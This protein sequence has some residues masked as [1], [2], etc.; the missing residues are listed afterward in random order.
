MASKKPV[1]FQIAEVGPLNGMLD[2]R[3]LPHELPPNA[4]RWSE[5]MAATA[6]GKVCRRPG[7]EKLFG[8]TTTY[9]NQDLHDQ[10]FDNL[11]QPITLLFEA[12]ST[13][14]THRLIAGT[15]NRLYALN[16]STGNWRVLSDQYGGPALSS[17]SDRN[18]YAA[19]VEDTVVFTNGSDPVVSWPFDGAPGTDDQSVSTIPD[20]ETLHITRAD[21]V[22][23][24]KGVLFLANITADGVRVPYRIVWS[25]F[26]KPL[27]FLP[28]PTVSVAGSHDL[29]YGEDV[30]AM[31]PLADSLLI[32]TTHGIWEAQVTGDT[33]VFSF[34]QR[35]AEPLTGA[36]C[37]AYKRTIVSTGSE[38]VYFGRDGL[39]AYDFYSPKPVRVEW[40]HRASSVIFDE[41]EDSLC[42][43]H[44][45]GWNPNK[46]EVWF[47]WA[48]KGDTNRCPYRTLVVNTEYQFCDVIKRGF[49][50]F[51]SY[52]PT[53]SSSVRDFLLQQCIC[54]EEELESNDVNFVNEGGFCRTP[55]TPTCSVAANSFYNTDSA[56]YEGVETEDF[57]GTVDPESLCALLGSVTLEQL[58]AEEAQAQ[59]CEAAQRFVVACTDDKCLKQ[60]GT[61][62]AHEICTNP[63][64]CATY[65]LQGYDSILRSGP[66]GFGAPTDLKLLRRF[67]L[68]YIAELQTVPSNLLV[69]I[70]EAKQPSDP[71]LT[72]SCPVIWYNLPP[73]ALACGS[74]K[75]EAQ[76]KL[77]RTRPNIAMEWPVFQS[78]LYLFWELKISGTGGAACFSGIQ[79]QVGIRAA[80]Y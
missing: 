34:R 12:R 31:L 67:L 76:H 35:Y 4:F 27:S 15:Q 64:V 66:L 72:D 63:T 55:T 44:V 11:R 37:L 70:G 74:P 39:Y 53:V 30:L 51:C 5:N 32:Y 2:V 75:T 77:D 24:W 18:W 79:M 41:L 49:T 10:L 56:F 46:R 14:G 52:S 43:L 69:R 60:Y 21:V 1:P 47:S 73:K 80:N 13:L 54:T 22:A 8:E 7:L 58:C 42:A 25:D 3:S 57:D 50:A 71:N 78:G 28:A 40:M 38:H 9:N 29:G 45:A 36:G 59:A 62:Y 65:Q 20:L 68:N 19:Q 17:C 33:E 16:N 6:K 23:S 26:R 48:R 61:I